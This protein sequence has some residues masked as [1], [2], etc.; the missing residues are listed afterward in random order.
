M[1]SMTEAWSL[2]AKDLAPAQRRGAED[3]LIQNTLLPA[4]SPLAVSLPRA[5]VEFDGKPR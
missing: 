1:G 4:R 5:A 2:I 3:A